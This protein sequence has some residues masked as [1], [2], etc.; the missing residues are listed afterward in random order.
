MPIKIKR[1]TLSL[2]ATAF[3]YALSS[4]AAMADALDD[5]IK[6]MSLQE[7]FGQMYQAPLEITSVDEI[8]DDLRQSI[9]DGKIGSFINPTS[10]ELVNAL[11]KIAV[12]EGNGIPILFAR[13]VI[14][15]YKTI[16]PIPL[17]QAASWNPEGAK[18]GAQIAAREASS[19][20]IRWTFSPMID[21]SRDPRW[22]RIAESYGEDP[23]LNSVFGVATIKGYQGEDMSNE[24][25]IA[26]CAKHFLGYGAATGGRDYNTTYIPEPLLHNVY[27]PPF[28]AAI[29]EA[30]VA[31]VM[32]AFNDLNGV[33]ASVN[34]DLLTGILRDE[35][36]F[37]GMVVSDWDS[38]IETVVHGVSADQAD[39][40]RKAINAGV[41]MEMVSR[42]FQ[43]NGAQL[44][45]DHKIS[46]AQIDSKVKRVLRL[47]SNL[48][49]F[50][51]PYTDTSRQKSML[52]DAHLKAAKQAAIESLVLL[53][54]T[55]N[56][57]P[58]N[59]TMKVA[60]IGPMA[61]AAHDQMG[62]WALDG[63]KQHSVTVLSAF[64]DKLNPKKLRYA[65]GLE[66]SRS[67]SHKGFKAALKIAKKADVIVY[68]G[69]EES[70]LSGEAH[71]RADIRMPGAQEALVKALSA[72][73]KP[74]VVVLMAGRPLALNDVIANMDA[75]VMAWH[76]GTMGGPAI[77]DL[78]YGDAEPSG[79]LP[80]TWPKVTGQVPMYY[81]KKNTG[82]PARSLP[83]TF[84]A[85]YPKEAHQHTLGHAT[86]YMDIGYEPQFPFGFGLSYSTMEYAKLLQSIN[87]AAGTVRVSVE[88][89]NTGTRKTTETVQL[90]VRDVLGSITRPI[91]ELKDFKQ[92]TLAAGESRI[93]EFELT[94]D[95]LSFFNNKGVKVFEP[96]TFEYWIGAN[97]ASKEKASFKL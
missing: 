5:R 93:V 71:S 8:D 45:R 53:K 36:Q 2:I 66:T 96:G 9:I 17:A 18:D 86:H 4:N 55:D 67:L 94:K 84:M 63:E 21:I 83:F 64:T 10:V 74:I 90:Y 13:D 92:V 6:A 35:L 47:K 46:D 70:F 41:D 7:K 24:E 60:L 31:T 58:L 33:P 44:L 68:V 79:R 54:N 27:L 82:R 61:D 89:S 22:G 78:L 37:K 14:H 50:E 76:P 69:G 88:L 97:A 25:R 23:L 3:G 34:G 30:N 85:D 59:P 65:E 95:Q 52:S 16:F 81:N 12:E 43:E 19:A 38:V 39:A 40:A 62:T 26:A 42:S 57:L 48:G 51:K 72:S 1:V 15:G 77:A 80:I 75:V 91:K 20:G 73:G 56:L 32:S 28:Q 49:L 29:E 87:D 11:Q